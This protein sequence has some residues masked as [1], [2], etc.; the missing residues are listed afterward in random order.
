MESFIDPYEAKFHMDL[1]LFT[2]SE[3]LRKFKTFHA[4]RNFNP[5]L[6]V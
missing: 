3:I 4:K 5:N 1:Q 2:Q 6:F